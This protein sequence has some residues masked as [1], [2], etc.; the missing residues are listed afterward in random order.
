M[1]V[2]GDDEELLAAAAEGD[3][4]AFSVFYRRNLSA[5]SGFFLRRVPSREMAFDLTAETF[6]A[7]VAG[8][9]GFD[10]GRGSARGWLFAIAVNELRQLWRAQQVEDRAR[11]RL[12]LEPIAL[13]DAALELVEQHA[14]PGAFEQALAALPAAERDAVQ[15]RIIDERT[16][17]ELAERW[18][19]SQAVVRQRVSRGLSRLRAMTEEGR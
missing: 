15:S 11:R 12:A 16:Y 1:V 7:V 10:P 9:G 2:V 5:V 4:D 18:R 17:A 14:D 8:L 19:C 13:D 6:A 3:A